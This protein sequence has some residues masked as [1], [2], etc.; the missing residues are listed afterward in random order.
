ML[1]FIEPN[2]ANCCYGAA[3][4][5]TVRVANRGWQQ[6][7]VLPLG[8]SVKNLTTGAVVVK[9]DTVP[10][11][12]LPGGTAT[13][14]FA[15]KA[16]LSAVGNYELRAW[17]ELGSDTVRRNDTTEVFALQ[18]TPS[19]SLPYYENFDGPLWQLGQGS[20]YAGTLDTTS[21]QRWP[22]P[23][24]QTGNANTTFYVGQDLTPVHGTGP[25]W[26]RKNK[27]KYVYVNGA[28]VT[29]N[30]VDYVYFESAKCFDFSSATAP[31]LAFWYH[32]AGAG[33]GSFIVEYLAER[34]PSVWP[35]DTAARAWARS[36]S[37]EMHSGFS[38]VRHYCTMNCGVRVRLHPLPAPQAAEL[39]SEWARIDALWCEGLE[40]FGGP[41]LAGSAFTAVDAFYAP[42]AFRAQ[43]YS[44]ELSA[45][46][47]AYVQRL[48]ELP[49]MRQWYQEA[50]I[51]PWRDEPHEAEVRSLGDILS[52]GRRSAP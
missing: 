35:R 7:S 51:E 42:V 46:A 28:Q 37:A 38:A 43:T 6:P 17:V 39:A 40:R 16:N 10:V 21:W 2:A 22:P 34:E 36:A 41:F 33:C 13:V 31:V 30:G 12:W 26:S 3:N 1:A 24:N 45:A 4:N 25:R 29:P 20:I 50:L 52:D 47:R 5:V 15:D 18:R 32:M 23:T 11:T 19:F 49:A 44:P 8:F 14:S 27:G 9:H 48:L